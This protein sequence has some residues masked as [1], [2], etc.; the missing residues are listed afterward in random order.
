MARTSTTSVGAR[1]SSSIRPSRRP[2]PLIC[3]SSSLERASNHDVANR[4]G[5]RRR[6]RRDAR[7]R[8]HLSGAR[9]SRDRRL[10]VARDIGR[11]TLGVARVGTR[12][13]SRLLRRQS[14]SGWVFHRMGAPAR[15]GTPCAPSLVRSVVRGA[16]R[17]VPLK[18]CAA[19]AHHWRSSVECRLTGKFSEATMC[20]GSRW[21]PLAV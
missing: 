7:E 1:R 21:L 8:Q 11:R 14:T 10:D 19:T 12:T 20:I 13:G 3:R 2:S 18:T 17:I 16:A 4:F 15:G 5:R 6:S 9:R